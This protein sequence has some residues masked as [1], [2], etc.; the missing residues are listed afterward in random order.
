MMDEK[1]TE[2]QLNEVT[3]FLEENRNDTDKLLE[4]IEKEHENDDNSNVPLEEGIGEFIGDGIILESE[5]DIDDFSHLDNIDA[6][7]EKLTEEKIKND[8]NSK[9]N[10][11]DEEALQFASIISRIRNN[12]EFNVYDELPEQLKEY[13]NKSIPKNDIPA[14][15]KH[16]YLNSVS[17]LMIQELISDSEFDALSIDLEKAMKELLPTPLEMYSETNKDYIENEFL[18]VAEKIKDTEPEKAKNLLEMRDGFINA[19]TFENMYNLLNTTNIINKVRKAD[20]LWSRIENEYK[21]VAKVCKFKLYPLE[22]TKNDL[23]KIGLTKNAAERLCA[24][25]VYTYTHGIENYSDETEYNS[26]KRNSFANYFELNMRNLTIMN[27]LVS[28]FSKTIKENLIKLSSC[29]E[30]RVSERETELLNNKKKRR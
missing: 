28:D 18:T 11:S 24:L 15:Q 2:N 8:L 4:K 23:I 12:E 5:D 25:F 16:A 10:L 27:N 29:I 3:N 7:L 20:K 1:L 17:T 19:Y 21:R 30:Q 6:D 26:I 9:F 14:N 13:I 22:E